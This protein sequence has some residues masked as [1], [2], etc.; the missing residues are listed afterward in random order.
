MAKQLFD[1]VVPGGNLLLVE[2]R[3]HVSKDTL[4]GEARIFETAGFSI[5]QTTI[6]WWQCRAVLQKL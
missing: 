2:P 3:F 6:G 1:C 5:A 4:L